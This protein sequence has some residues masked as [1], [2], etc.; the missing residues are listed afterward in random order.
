MQ[1]DSVDAWWWPFAFILLAGWLPSDIW[2]AIGALAAGWIDPDGE[3]LVLVRAIAN[4]LVAA[5]I[6]RFVFAPT[7]ALA[8]VPMIL[9]LAAFVT[10]LAAF[11]LGGRR[12]VIGIATGEVLLLAAWFAST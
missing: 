9:R 12:L 11:L 2:R 6:A 8:E 1:L 5:V 7:G 4:A 3:W 10:A